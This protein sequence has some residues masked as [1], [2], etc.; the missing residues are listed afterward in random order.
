M[1]ENG[2]GK[3][4][5]KQRP[6]APK[7]QPVIGTILAGDAAQS[8]WRLPPPHPPPPVHT[9][10][11]VTTRREG[12]RFKSKSA[13]RRGGGPW[14]QTAD[15]NSPGQSSTAGSGHDSDWTLAAGLVCSTPCPTPQGG[16]LM[17]KVNI[18]RTRKHHPA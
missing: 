16:W 8:R 17:R 5:S 13:R 6:G 2:G 9:L 4:E 10:I 3:F 7:T 1:K 11:S 14:L 18:V 15:W 12:G